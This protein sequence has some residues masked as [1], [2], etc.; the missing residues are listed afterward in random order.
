MSGLHADA[1]LFFA[2]FKP[3]LLTVILHKKIA[4]VLAT[5]RQTDK[6]PP[7]G[8]VRGPKVYN[9]FLHNRFKISAQI[10]LV[11]LIKTR[12]WW[13]HRIFHIF[14]CF[15][16]NIFQ[17]YFLILFFVENCQSLCKIKSICSICLVIDDCFMPCWAS[18]NKQLLRA[19]QGWAHF[20]NN[21]QN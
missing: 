6:L 17:L 2:T 16:Y 13:L 9:L 10:S 1:T 21:I 5:N 14:Q 18:A 8:I 7:I 20:N 3:I 15:S 12:C 4:V 19:L 11:E